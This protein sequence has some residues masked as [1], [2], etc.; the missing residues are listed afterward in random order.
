MPA[1]PIDKDELLAL[2]RDPGFVIA[3]KLLAEIVHACSD[4]MASKIA[5]GALRVSAR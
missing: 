4:R 1:A 2:I 5:G 3:G